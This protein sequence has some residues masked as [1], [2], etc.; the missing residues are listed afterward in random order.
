MPPETTARYGSDAYNCSREPGTEL[1]NPAS[2]AAIC[3]ES[4]FIGA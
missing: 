2:A 1:E 4:I 3:G